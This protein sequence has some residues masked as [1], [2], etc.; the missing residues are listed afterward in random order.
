MC[1]DSAEFRQRSGKL[2]GNQKSLSEVCGNFKGDGEILFEKITE[3]VV[4]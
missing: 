2:D 3:H 1:A 4:K